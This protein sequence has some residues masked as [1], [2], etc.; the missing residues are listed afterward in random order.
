M[1]LGKAGKL[2]GKLDPE[3]IAL[4]KS[5][6]LE[7][8][9]GNPQDNYPNV[10]P[11]YIKEMEE[12]GWDRGQDDEELFEFAMHDK[13]YRDFKSGEAKKRFNA[14]LREAMEKEFKT[15]GKEINISE[16][17]A[18][19]NPDGIP[20]TAPVSGRIMW[21]FDFVDHSIKP[22]IGTMYEQGDILCAIQTNGHGLEVVPAL[23]PGRIVDVV[24]DQ[25]TL[26]QKGDIIAYM[27]K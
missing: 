18:L 19:C 26:V 15:A 6:N 16:L 10:L 23:F 25:G 12:L 27:E 20:V 22:A 24:A 11:K 7:F 1:I 8:F 4:A 5:K 9:E 21:E 14:E 17:K 2:P 3:I 13:Q